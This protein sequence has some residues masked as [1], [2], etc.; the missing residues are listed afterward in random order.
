M[1]LLA[2]HLLRTLR[3][4]SWMDTLW[5]DFVSDFSHFTQISIRSTPHLTSAALL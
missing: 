2:L 4:L 1:S 5:C 3:T